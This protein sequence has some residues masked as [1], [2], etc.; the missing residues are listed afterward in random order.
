MIWQDDGR[1][2]TAYT[3]KDE[4]YR[5]D[6]DTTTHRLSNRTSFTP[7]PHQGF[8]NG[9][10]RDVEGRIYNARVTGSAVARFA[11]DG[12]ELDLIELPM[13][14]PTSCT[15]GG[16]GLT[17]LFVTSARFGIDREELKR[18]PVEGALAKIELGVKGQPQN[19][20]I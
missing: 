16:P 17:T 14:Q 12:R 20:F 8:P 15:F 3:P 11:P 7:S 13:R 10:A 1:F 18:T 19:L 2:V 5:Y 6:Y 9:S 4:L